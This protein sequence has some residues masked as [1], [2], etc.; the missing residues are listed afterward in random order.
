MLSKLATEKISLEQCCFCIEQT[1]IYCNLLIRVLL[2][3]GAQLSVVHS[4]EMKLIFGLTRGKSDKVDAK[5][6]AEYAYCY[7]DKLMV[8]QPKIAVVDELD[9]LC[10]L[11]KKVKENEES[12]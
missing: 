4:A 7:N 8:Y 3:L 11:Q 1:G 9:T 10:K 5:R 6:I 2:D 12:T